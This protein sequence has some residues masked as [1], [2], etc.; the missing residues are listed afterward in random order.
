MLDG[1]GRHPASLGSGGMRMTS[2]LTLSFSTAVD[3]CQNPLHPDPKPLNST[4]IWIGR[5]SLGPSGGVE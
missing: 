3:W 1:G 4:C 5:L 2:V